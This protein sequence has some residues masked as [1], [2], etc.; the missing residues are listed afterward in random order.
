MVSTRG[1]TRAIFKFPSSRKVIKVGFPAHN[2]AEYTAY[3]LLC[4]NPIG[5]ILAKCSNI[6]KNG[7]V[8]EQEFVY[9]EFPRAKDLTPWSSKCWIQFRESIEKL[10]SPLNKNYLEFDFHEE[11]MRIDRAGD[12]KLIDYSAILCE[13]FN[14]GYTIDSVMSKMR[15]KASK[16]TSNID[17]Y[18]ENGT[19]FM[20]LNGTQTKFIITDNTKS[21]S[22]WER[23][24]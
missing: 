15:H 1:S 22:G 13:K 7:F 24:I 5:R 19:V 3:N 17:L 12:I 18:Y 21:H 10:F 9:K 8:L 4:L 6:S 14:K 16:M 11:N 23:V 2:R 20:N